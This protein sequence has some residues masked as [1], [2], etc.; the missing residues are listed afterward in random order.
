MDGHLDAAADLVH[1]LDPLRHGLPPDRHRVQA[2]DNTPC[3]YAARYNSLYPD[4]N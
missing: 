2:L 3:G 4:N 1:L